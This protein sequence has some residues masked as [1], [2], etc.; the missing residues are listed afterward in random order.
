MQIVVVSSK[1]VWLNIV[2]CNAIRKREMKS[3][4]H[5]TVH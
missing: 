5:L 4:L 1:Q 3:F 2:N